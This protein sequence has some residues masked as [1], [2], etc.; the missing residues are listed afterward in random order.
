M[1]RTEQKLYEL[2]TIDCGETNIKEAWSN[3]SYGWAHNAQV[4]AIW[5]NNSFMLEINNAAW[6]KTMA[7]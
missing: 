6:K 3:Q 4:K 5:E 2:T 1:W 7:L